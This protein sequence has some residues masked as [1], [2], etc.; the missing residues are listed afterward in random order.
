MNPRRS[1]AVAAVLC[2][3]GV[4]AWFA[5]SG[6]A[7][8]ENTAAPTLDRLAP[9]LTADSELADAPQPKATGNAAIGNIDVAT[10]A[11]LVRGTATGTTAASDEPK[12]IVEAALTDSSQ[13]LPPETPPLPAV[14]T[15]TPDAVLKDTRDVVGS[16]EILDECW[17]ADVCFDRYLWALYQRT[18]KEDAIK[19]DERRKVT[20][21][22]KGKTVT[23]T[24]TFTKL[25]DEDFAWKDPKAAEKSR[26]PMMDYVIGGMDRSFKQKLFYM[27]HA[28]EGA[29]LSPGITSAF[30]DD[31]RQSIAS[32]LKAATDR[33]YHGGSFRGGYGHGLAADVVSVKGGTRAQRQISTE[34][35]WKWIDAHEKEFGIGRP[36][37]DRDPPHVAPI[38]GKEYA[39]HRGT[40][41]LHA[42]SDATQRKA[43]RDDESVAKRKRAAR[44]SKVRTI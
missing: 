24:K 30:R 20:V 41:A 16:T 35:L 5:G 6:S 8:I 1:A 29:G 44:S 13:M 22:R 40:K 36:Y 32:G 37:L 27:L 31:Y 15:S 43:V 23:V 12:S 21:K 38:D 11:E 14:T 4:V 25:V 17:V 33:S 10:T 2:G 19:V 9:F 18:P 28:A 42:A 7:G 34:S 3:T 26:I 39:A